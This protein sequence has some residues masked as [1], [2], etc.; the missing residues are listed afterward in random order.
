MQENT[1]TNLL[2][3]VQNF[4]ILYPFITATLFW[5]FAILNLIYAVLLFKKKKKKNDDNKRNSDKKVTTGV[6]I[7]YA[8]ITALPFL[9][10]GFTAFFLFK[11]LIIKIIRLL[12]FSIALIWIWKKLNKLMLN[13]LSE[14]S[15][16]YGGAFALILGVMLTAAGFGA[17][18]I[19][20]RLLDYFL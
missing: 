16:A 5:G 7:L 10:M 14:E 4:D 8:L 20:F 1:H 18:E 3:E 11:T 19:V 2:S 9:G 12:V 13:E 6:V 15:F 17:A